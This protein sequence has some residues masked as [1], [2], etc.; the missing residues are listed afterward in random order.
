LKPNNCLGKQMMERTDP[1]QLAAAFAK[2]GIKGDVEWESAGALPKD[3]EMYRFEMGGAQYV[4]LLPGK[5]QGVAMSPSGKKSLEPPLPLT[6]RLPRKM[7]V[8]NM[9]TGSYLGQG[10]TLKGD[11]SVDSVALF[12]LLPYQVNGVEASAEGA[13][14]HARVTAT[15]KPTDHVLHIEVT[16][17]QGEKC[18]WYSRNIPAPE[19]AAEV[20]IPFALSDPTGVWTAQ[21]TDVATGAKAT[22]QL[23]R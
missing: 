10:A 18:P 20:E 16:S 23:K 15:A 5:A 3:A 22:V 2:L 12:S 11:L 14:I 8:Y 7:H 4:A 19:G 13:V 1:D 21:V 9:R 6:V 17:P